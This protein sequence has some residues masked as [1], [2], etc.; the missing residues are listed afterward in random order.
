MPFDRKRYP[1]E[2]PEI[3]KRIKERDGNKCKWCKVPNGAVGY[4]DDMGAFWVLYQNKDEIDHRADSLAADGIKLITI[5]LTVAHLGVDKPDGSPGDKHDK[6]D[7]REENLA[8]LCQRCHLNYDRDEH[9]LN[10]A[11]TRRQKK[12]K[13]GQMVLLD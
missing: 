10:S 3:I 4:R 9:A 11:K 13:A 7:C 2:W 12:I 6:M 1:K 5:V 8:A